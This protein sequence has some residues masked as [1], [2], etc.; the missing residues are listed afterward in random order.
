LEKLIGHD[1]L[2]YFKGLY[3][4]FHSCL[5]AGQPPLGILEDAVSELNNIQQVL[6][7]SSAIVLQEV[8]V[9]ECYSMSPN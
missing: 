1:E 9:G 2:M 3:M 8:G 6:Q 4:Q 7:C 5:I